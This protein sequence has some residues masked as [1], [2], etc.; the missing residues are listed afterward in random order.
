MSTSVCLD[1]SV[2]WSRIFAASG[3]GSQSTGETLLGLVLV[4]AIVSSLDVTFLLGGI[5][6]LLLFPFP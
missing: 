6:M 5:A 4:Q 2:L 3:K 1:R